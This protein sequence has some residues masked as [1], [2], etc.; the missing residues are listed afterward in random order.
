LSTTYSGITASAGAARGGKGPEVD[1]PGI[2]AA[3]EALR[4]RRA[5][6][7]VVAELDRLSRSMLEFAA[8]MD[9]AARE[10]WALVALDLGVDT[11]TPAGEMMA[12][13]LATFAQC[14]RR[15]IA[16]RTS[17]ALAAKRASGTVLGRP[18]T[19]PASVLAR[20]QTERAAGRTLSAIAD[21][22]SSDAIPTV[23]GGRRW[24]ASTVR[25]ALAGL[26]SRS[27]RETGGNPART[28]RDASRAG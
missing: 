9:R 1:R 27:S 18:R 22:L 21:G 15:P 26:V 25:K 7:L 3:L 6:T 28:S 10:H 12:N 4:R 20:I 17:D 5:D 14:E 8:L 13:V 2:A 11:T 24:Y 19:M 23:Q 16:Q